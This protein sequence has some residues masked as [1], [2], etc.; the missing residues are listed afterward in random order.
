MVLCADSS[1]SPSPCSRKCGKDPGHFA[2]VCVLWG[3]GV[4]GRAGVDEVLRLSV[5][6]VKTGMTNCK[7]NPAKSKSVISNCPHGNLLRRSLDWLTLIDIET[8]LNPEEGL[9]W[10]PKRAQ[11]QCQADPRAAVESREVSPMESAILSECKRYDVYYSG[12]VHWNNLQ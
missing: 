6:L 12:E 7:V 1:Q 10:A 11:H 9:A 5:E 8:K 4:G 2:S 3:G